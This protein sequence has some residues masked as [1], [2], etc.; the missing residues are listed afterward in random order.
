M[1]ESATQ[2]PSDER[3]HAAV[4]F[5]ASIGAIVLQIH[6][7]PESHG[8]EPLL[9]R[10]GLNRFSARGL[11]H[12]VARHA[13]RA[14]KERADQ[15]KA[16]KALKEL[17]QGSTGALS[18]ARRARELLEIRASGSLIETVC[19]KAGIDDLR[20]VEHLERLTKRDGQAGAELQVMATDIVSKWK[21]DQG[22]RKEAP[23]IAHEYLQRELGTR[24]G[25]ARYS[26]SDLEEGFVDA[27]SRAT[28]IEFGL[29]RF[30]PR[31]AD[32]RRNR[33]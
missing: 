32:R 1:P 30:D 12:L 13:V 14:C 19:E 3:A 21:P 10:R 5:F 16:V 33:R 6:N 7:L 29:L 23:S 31:P 18:R 4:Q 9:R 24:L 17:A 11:A 15:P 25:L 20:F 26:Y 28:A 2:A 22:P 27:A 8:Y